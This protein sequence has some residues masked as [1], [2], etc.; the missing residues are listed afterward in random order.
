MFTGE[1]GGTLV[2]LRDY[3]FTALF[4]ILMLSHLR[5]TE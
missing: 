5:E 4:L 2:K 1:T 3:N